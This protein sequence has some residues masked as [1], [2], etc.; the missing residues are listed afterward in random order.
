MDPDRL[1][2]LV[3]RLGH[4]LQQAAAFS[5][6]GKSERHAA[7]HSHMALSVTSV[8]L[9]SPETRS[10]LP[11]RA[12]EQPHPLP[13]TLPFLF[14]FTLFIPAT[15]SISNSSTSPKVS[16]QQKSSPPYWLKRHSQPLTCLL[17]HPF[18][19]SCF[20]GFFFYP[21]KKEREKRSDGV[22]STSIS[23]L[24]SSWRSKPR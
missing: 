21:S 13:P 16:N 9:N 8:I 19:S 5:V 1:S 20:V 14:M 18:L 2:T 17:P 11:A 15:T 7:A 6:R 22:P 12:G 24:A 23:K 4:S 3:H 10:P